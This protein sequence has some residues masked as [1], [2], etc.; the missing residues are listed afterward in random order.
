MAESKWL[1]L[2]N[3]C[4]PILAN[5]IWHVSQLAGKGVIHIGFIGYLADRMVYPFSPV[6]G[7][8]VADSLLIFNL[9]ISGLAIA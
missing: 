8:G 7:V 1:K 9:I 3:V 2:A 6:S 5:Y 4:Y